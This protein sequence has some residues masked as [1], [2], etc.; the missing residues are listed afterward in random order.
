MH[1][2]HQYMYDNYYVSDDIIHNA[3]EW[4]HTEYCD[5]HKVH[6]YIC[7]FNFYKQGSRV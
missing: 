3:H 6:M 4:Q 7:A 2:T 1:L 5:Y